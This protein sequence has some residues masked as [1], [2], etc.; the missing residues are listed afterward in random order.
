MSAAESIR[1]ELVSIGLTES[2]ASNVLRHVL[3]RYLTQL[4][5]SHNEGG[6]PTHNVWDAPTEETVDNLPDDLKPAAGIVM[7]ALVQI[8][9]A[10]SLGIC[11]PEITLP[12]RYAA[13]MVQ[14]AARSVASRAA[15]R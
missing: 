3:P 8:G 2:G 6:Y 11:N 5:D 14:F 9:R 7:L 4:A 13:E 10:A 12:M 1:A 15:A